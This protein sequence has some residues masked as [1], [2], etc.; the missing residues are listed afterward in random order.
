MKISK[1]DVQLSDFFERAAKEINTPKKMKEYI[2]G[3]NKAFDLTKDPD[4]ILT[5]LKIIA[6]AKGNISQL[7]RESKVERRSIYNMFQKGSNPT[8]KNLVAVSQKLGIN[9][10]LDFAPSY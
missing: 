6:I 4:I 9:L 5:A 3:V 2:K 1:K 8:L 7:A 10:H